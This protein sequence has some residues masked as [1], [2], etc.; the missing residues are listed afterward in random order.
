MG[1]RIGDWGSGRTPNHPR[2]EI[3]R[4]RERHE[5]I[6]G[7]WS[8]VQGSGFRVQGSGFRVQ[9]LGLRVQG[10]ELRRDKDV[11]MV[12]GGTKEAKS[13]G[14]KVMSGPKVNHE[15]KSSQ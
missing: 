15:Q 1:I 5:G 7:R 14:H 9:G 11:S 6:N 10:L 13:A 4:V 12:S 3:E 2:K 8:R